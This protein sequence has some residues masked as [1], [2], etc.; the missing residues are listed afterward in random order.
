MEE[1]AGSQDIVDTWRTQLREFFD[2]VK[3]IA[4]GDGWHGFYESTDITED[5]FGIGARI[6]YKAPVLILG[7][8]FGKEN[9]SQQTTFEPRHQNALGSAG[10]IDVYS[11]PEMR[12]AMLLRVPNTNG[13]QGLTQE[14]TEKLVA[15]TPWTAFSQ[16]RMRLNADLSNDEGVR[17]SLTEL[18]A[19]R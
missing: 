6:A 8:P 15:E 17:A 7:R 11:Y 2:H 3:D 4:E 13:A 18:V 19:M 10:R 12:E 9:I 5:L 1:V 14:A 16:E